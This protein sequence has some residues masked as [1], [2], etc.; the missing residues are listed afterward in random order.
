MRSFV[1]VAVAGA[2]CARWCGVPS[3]SRPA[4]LAV[5][6]S[7]NGSNFE[8]LAAAAAREDLGGRIV[9]LLCDRPGAPV[10]DRARRHGIE[11]L[12]PTGHFRAAR[13]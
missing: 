2:F 12:T 1:P 8:S 7:G 10:L 13:G 5:F 4:R 3:M 11:A 9:V 6:A